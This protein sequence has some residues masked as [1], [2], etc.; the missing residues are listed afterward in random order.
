MD[1]YVFWAVVFFLGTA[2]AS[3]A[4]QFYFTRKILSSVPTLTRLQVLFGVFICLLPFP[5]LA[6]DVD[7]ALAAKDAMAAG[8]TVPT[9]TV[10]STASD[11][12]TLQAGVPVSS[13]DGWINAWW[14]TMF[15]GTQ[16]LGW[17]TL[18]IAQS[19]D[20]SGEFTPK[21]KFKWA[22]KENIRLYIILAVVAV[23]LMGYL[24]F[25]KG[26]R[27]VGGIVSLCLAAANAFGLTI[28]VIFLGSGVF[29]FP[30]RM[31]Q[32]A[33]PRWLLEEEFVAARL[34]SEDLDAARLDLSSLRGEL[35]RMDPSV[36]D[37][38]RPYF[39]M[40][41]EKISSITTNYGGGGSALAIRD[42]A[43][44]SSARGG[45]TYTSLT[46]MNMEL[47]RLG[48]LIRRLHTQFQTS[49]AMC[50][51]LDKAAGTGGS[52]YWTIGRKPLLRLGAICALCLSVFVL[53]NE[54]LVPF[55]HITGISL[56]LLQIFIRNQAT[57]FIASM[58]L[59]CYVASCAFWSTV[60]F[61]VF[62]TYVL[63]PGVTDAASLCFFATFMT[64]LI[65]PLCYNFLLMA[66]MVGGQWGITYS[67]LFGA[68]NVVDLL[69]VWFNRFM[70]LFIPIIAVLIE[71]GIIHRMLAWA[72]FES[73]EVSS[74]SKILRQ[75]QMGEGR[76]IV[77]RHGNVELT[78]VTTIAA[79]GGQGVMSGIA[80]AVTNVVAPSDPE[81]SREEKAKKYA[82]WKAK[83]QPSGSGGNG[84]ESD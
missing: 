1:G 4:T 5:L 60:K 34:I 7:A 66:D 40:M 41:L 59:L 16:I 26:V 21:A 69:G 61:R 32:L 68:M 8:A 19:F 52:W 55:N 51:S 10:T 79:E 57:R 47:R 6:L 12:S 37:H 73:F 71:L 42:A 15:F 78:A 63:V 9:A 67:R 72:G 23:V 17:I 81:R 39:V 3:A 27:D 36:S 44:S 84:K 56:S 35:A 22:I 11:G 77:M 54:I 62:D 50:I 29:G 74:E 2:V 24:I 18:P 76:A 13:A 33:D 25:L 82:E 70:P 65:M 43:V 48:K 53:I 14:M 49:V 83:Q 64:R 20:E 31:W 28:L 38:D 45:K 30:R 75:Q 46:L 80:H 58:T